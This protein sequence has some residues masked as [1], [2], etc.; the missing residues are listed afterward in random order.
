LFVGCVAH[1][2]RTPLATQRSLLELALADSEIDLETWQEIGGEVLEAC[3]RQERLL[4][5]CLALVR[6]A[7]SRRP[8]EPVD[9][10][11]VAAA[12]LAEQTPCAP[13]I[14]SALDP[15]PTVGDRC[16][17]ERLVANLVSNAIRHNRPG[18]AINLA[19]G[20]V[21]G[22]PVL[23]IRNTGPV[24]AAADVPQLFEPFNRPRSQSARPAGGLG[25]GL[26]IVHAIA[27]AHG[28]RIHAEPNPGGGL[29]V[30]VAF[31]AAAA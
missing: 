3:R 21:A 23:S 30:D 31:A 11:T 14:R 12:S 16:L 28:A 2:L 26:S 27:A 7:C 24:I 13:A 25:L 17:L 29:G 6:G 9:L 5:A 15:A 1:E 10:A 19:T 22:C 18:G 8:W 4:E 20:V